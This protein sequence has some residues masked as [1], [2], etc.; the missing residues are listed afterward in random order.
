MMTSWAYRGLLSCPSIF[1]RSNKSIY[2]TPS[3]TWSTKMQFAIPKN[4]GRY[5]L[6]CRSHVPF[7][8]VQII[9]WPP[10]VKKVLQSRACSISFKTTKVWEGFCGTLE[11]KNCKY[12]SGWY[13]VFLKTQLQEPKSAKLRGVDKG[14]SNSCFLLLA[15]LSRKTTLRSSKKSY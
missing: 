13:C 9:D 8:L 11:R 2:G 12:F 1:S 10:V 6:C 5:F 3:S 7:I 4:C 14:K 15:H